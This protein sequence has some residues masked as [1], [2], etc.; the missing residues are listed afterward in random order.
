MS[1]QAYLWRAELNGRQIELAVA[2]SRRLIDIL[3]TD[4]QQTGTKIS[5]EIGRCGACMV[6]IDGVA[7]NSCL[8]MA[9]QCQDRSIVTIEGLGSED[10]AD[11]A[12]AKDSTAEDDQKMNTSVIAIQG[13]KAILHPIQEAFVE[14]GGF[15]CGY[16]TPGMILST[17]ALLDQ[18]PSPVKADIEEALYGNL[19]R[20]TGYSGIIRAVEQAAVKC[21]QQKLQ[22]QEQ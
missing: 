6:L 9:Y 3:R 22:K 17:K 7:M 1:E 14:E 12:I 2:P 15:Q 21:R 19:C 16:C 13:K 18:N 4:L 8:L 10:C 20:C 11:R 5:C